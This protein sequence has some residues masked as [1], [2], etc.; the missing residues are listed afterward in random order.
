M[1]IAHHIYSAL[2]VPT[3]GGDAHDWNA[4]KPINDIKHILQARPTLGT[5]KR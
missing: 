4:T 5:L 2:Q 3:L 1:A